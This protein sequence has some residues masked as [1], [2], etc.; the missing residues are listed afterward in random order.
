MIYLYDRVYDV[1]TLYKKIQRL[2]QEKEA[3]RMEKEQT[4]RILS[5]LLETIW[6]NPS[7]VNS[8]GIYHHAV[9]YLKPAI[10]KDPHANDDLGVKL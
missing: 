3:E 6:A 2:E 10:T 4:R 8:T 9:N 1:E 7:Y 5:L